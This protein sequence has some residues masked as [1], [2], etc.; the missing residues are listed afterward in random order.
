MPSLLSVVVREQIRLIKPILNRLSIPTARAFQDALGELGTKLVAGRVTFEPV[1]TDGFE[2]CFALPV[3]ENDRR[4][5]I[6]Y[7]HGGA[8]V[9][10]NMKYARGFAGIL[11]DK[12]QKRVLSVVYR[13]APEHPFPAALEDALAAY[14]YLLAEGWEARQISFIGESAGG[15]LIFCLCLR[16]KQLGL[17]LPGALVGISPWTD[18]T[19]SGASYLA[20]ASKDPSLAVDVLRNHAAIYAGGKEQDPLVSPVFGD[21]TGMPPSLILAGGDELLLSDAEKLAERLMDSGCRCE[22]IVED[23]LWHVYVLFSIPEARAALDKIACF[24]QF[25]NRDKMER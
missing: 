6:L 8:Y 25:E 10:G 18:L 14:Q 21:L 1:P 2:G 9:A 19:F 16:L 11:A 5:V 15:G 13:L 7:L 12:L 20:N 24:L 22:L 17:P 4:Q 23:G 3:D